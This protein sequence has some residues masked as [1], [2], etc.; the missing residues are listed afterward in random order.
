MSEFPERIGA[1]RSEYVT[2]DWYELCYDEKVD[3]SDAEYIR[4]DI[5]AAKDDNFCDL[6]YQHGA[7][8]RDVAHYKAEITRLENIIADMSARE[9]DAAQAAEERTDG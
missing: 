9:V 7:A 6:A 1:G 3:A 4:A 8:L 5:V 2:Q